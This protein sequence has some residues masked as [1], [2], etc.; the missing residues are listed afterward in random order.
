[1]HN[2]LIPYDFAAWQE[3][4]QYTNEKATAMLGIS[5]SFYLT[6]KREA[7]ARKT[8]VWAAYGIEYARSL[9]HG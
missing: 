6:I 1:M 8:Y 9:A 4:M 5:K 2:E 7:K 3:R